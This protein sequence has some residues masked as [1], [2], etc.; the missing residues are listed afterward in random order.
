MRAERP[1]RDPVDPRRRAVIVAGGA[2]VLGAAFRPLRAAA[3]TKQRIGIISTGHIGGTIGELWVKAGHPVFFSSRHPEE[4]TDLVAR[5]GPLAKAGTVDQAIAFGDVVFHGCA[6][7]RSA[8]DRETVRHITCRQDRARRRQC[9]GE[10]RRHYRRRGRARLA[11]ELLAEIFAGHSAGARL[12]HDVNYKIFGSE[13][14]EPI[15]SSRCRSPATIPDAVRDRGGAGAR[16]RV[17]IPVVVGELADAKP[18]FSAAGR[19]TARQVSAAELRAEA[20]ARAA[21]RARAR[22]EKSSYRGGGGEKTR[23]QT[24]RRAMARALP[25]TPQERAAALWSF[26]Y[27]FTL[28]AGYYVLRPLRDQ[29][30]I[31]GGIPN[32]PWL[33][34]A[35]FATLLVA[36]PLYGMLGREAAARPFHS[37]RQSFFCRQPRAVCGCSSRC[38]SD[39]ALVGRGMFLRV[40]LPF[41]QPV[42]GGG[43]LVV[44][45]RPVHGRPR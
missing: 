23:W 35:T 9:C 16:R 4:L 18:A 38:R 12:Q 42:L 40:G 11:S 34:T 7:R 2:L 8:G 37:D 25:A 6:L 36:Q 33:F 20:L 5:L 30:A 24:S 19:V 26:A 14:N 10:P 27:F 44:H 41:I 3:Q 15:R 28:L 17:S 31:T 43:V 29:M 39:T 45:G 32:L 13:A 21:E 1:N 22:G